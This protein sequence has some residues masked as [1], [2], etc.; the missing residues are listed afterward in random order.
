MKQK[1]K[2]S[3]IENSIYEFIQLHVFIK[4]LNKLNNIIPIALNLF[5]RVGLALD[6]PCVSKPNLP[7][8]SPNHNCTIF[9]YYLKN[10][11]FQNHI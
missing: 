11:L 3:I 1:N 10:Y 9:F 6:C 4:Y 2:E 8:P 7:I 5:A